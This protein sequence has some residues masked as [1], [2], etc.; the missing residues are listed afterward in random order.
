MKNRVGIIGKFGANENWC[1]GQTIKTKNL[2]MLLEKTK[3]FSFVKADT[4]YFKRKNI[5]LMFESLLCMFTCDHIFLMVSVNGMNFYLPFL[6]YLN[7]LTRR[8]IYHYIIGSELLEMVDKN[9]KLVKYLNSLTVNWFEYESGTQYLK[10]KGVTN[11]STLPNF[12]I[13]TPVDEPVM[14]DESSENF[15]FCTF[16]RVMAEK[17]ITEAINTISKINEEHGK[18]IATLDIYGQLEPKYEAEFKDLIMK[19]PDC[20]AYKGIVDSQK[21]AEVLKDYYA[22]LF[23]T[24]WVGEGFPGTAI[25]AFAAGLPVIASDWNA[26]KEIIKHNINGIIYPNKDMQTLKDAVEWSLKETET[27]KKMRF[28]NRAEFERYTPN[29]VLQVILSKMNET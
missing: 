15:R 14:Y 7:K 6:H 27:M 29:S 25:D 8:K 1:D 12:K 13:L 19:N 24:T 22:L 9:P 2:A 26:N 10:S 28:E 11:V 23:P 17:G 5:K 4:C 18:V 3:K 16:S 20:V 21:S